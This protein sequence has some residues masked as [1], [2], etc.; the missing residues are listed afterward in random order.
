[1][2]GGVGPMTVAMLLQNTTESAHRYLL[3]FD[4]DKPWKLSK[5]P[6]DIQTPVPTDIKIAKTH[7]PKN[8]AKLAKEIKIMEDEL[9]LYGSKKAK[10]NLSVY[11]RIKHRPNG[12]YVVVTGINPTPLGEGKSTTTVGLCQSLGAHL[13]KNTIGCLRQP[14]QGPTFGIKGNCETL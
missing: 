3:E 14:S 1:M 13:D 10:V 8:I 7:K 11:E 5:L 9:E 2:P 4:S 6:L 12:N